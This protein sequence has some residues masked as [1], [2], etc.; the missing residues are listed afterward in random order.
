MAID[1]HEMS[2]LAVLD[3]EALLDQASN[4]TLAWLANRLTDV[5]NGTTWP[6]R[7]AAI[8]AILDA[9]ERLPEK[10]PAERYRQR[11]RERI[12]TKEHPHA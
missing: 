11:R 2:E 12:W 8:R 6:S 1:Q 3:Y 4:S 9:N 7:D 5:P 10:H